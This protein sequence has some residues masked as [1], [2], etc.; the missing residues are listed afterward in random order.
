MG[1]IGQLPNPWAR[2]ASVSRTAKSNQ[3]IAASPQ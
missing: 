3:L 1:S 2:A